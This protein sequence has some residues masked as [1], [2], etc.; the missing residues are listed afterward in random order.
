[1]IRNQEIK[2]DEALKEPCMGKGKTDRLTRSEKAKIACLGK[3]RL[4]R[5]KIT[6]KELVLCERHLPEV[7]ICEMILLGRWT[8]I[9]VK[10]SNGII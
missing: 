9:R 2:K 8:R 3:K 10:E 1:M 4:Y 5:S 7:W 6:S